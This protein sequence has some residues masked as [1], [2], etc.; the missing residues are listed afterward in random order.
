MTRAILKINPGIAPVN[1]ARWAYLGYKGGSEPGV[2]TMSFLARSK[3]GNSYILA[4]VVNDSAAEIDQP[5][6][7]Q[8]MTRMLDVLAQQ[9]N[10]DGAP[11]TRP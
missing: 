11:A 3:Q 9:D 7:T 1:A 5:R 6:F 4:A 10:A 2:M 8:L